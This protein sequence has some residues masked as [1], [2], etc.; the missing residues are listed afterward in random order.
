LQLSGYETFSIALC[1]L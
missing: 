1:A